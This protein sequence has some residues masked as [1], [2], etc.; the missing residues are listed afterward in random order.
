MKLKPVLLL[1][2]AFLAGVNVF[3]QRAASFDIHLPSVVLQPDKNLKNDALAAIEKAT[4]RV[5]GRGMVILQFENTLSPSDR[6]LMESQGWR[7]EAFLDSHSFLGSYQGALDAKKLKA[8]GVRAVVEAKPSYK[9]SKELTD[10]LGAARGTDPSVEV[11]AGIIKSWDPVAVR[12]QLGDRGFVITNAEL[13]RYRVLELRCTKSQLMSLAALPFIEFVQV[14]PPADQPLNNKSIANSR[15]N[16]LRSTL[17]GQRALS[18]KN[19]VVG[20]GDD[21]SPAFHIDLANTI[22]RAGSTGATHGL[23][24]MT[25]LAGTGTRA[26]LFTGYAPASQLVAQIFSNILRYTDTYIQDHGMVLTNNSYGNIV[27]DCESFGL[28]DLYSSV[29]DQQHIV[30]PS[31]LHVFAAGNSGSYTCGAFPAGYHTVLG[32]YQSSKNAIMVAATDEFGVIAGYSS[33]GPVNDGRLKPDIAAQGTRVFSGIMN[34]NYG[35]SSGTSMAAPAVTG[36]LALLYERYRQLNGGADPDNYL[37]KALLLNGATDIDRPGPDYRSG[38]GWMN[39]LRSV[40][41]LE[42]N[43]FVKGVVAEGNT[44][45]HTFTIPSSVDYSVLKVMLCWND[46]QAAP[47]ASATLVNDLDLVVIGPDGQ[48]LQP[49]ILNSAA[50]SVESDAVAGVDRI[51]NTEQVTL[52][53][54]APGTYQIRI[55]GFRLSGSNQQEYAVVFDTIRQ[56]LELTFP[57][58]GEHLRTTDSTYITWDNNGLTGPSILEYSLD[59]GGSWNTMSN[60]IVAESKQFKWFWAAGTAAGRARVRI[61][62]AASGAV[63][64]SEPFSVLDVPFVSLTG[65][66]CPGYISISWT[67]VTGAD[68]YEV[69]IWSSG[70]MRSLGFVTGTSYT[71]AGLSRDSLYL[72][73]VRAIK[74]GVPGRRPTAVMR[75]P[76]SGNCASAVNDNDL[77]MD[78]LLSP[79]SGRAATTSALSSTTTVRVRIQNLDNVTR[80]GAL[81]FGYQIDQQTPVL[82]AVATSS[83]PALGTFSY[84]F[85]TPA[86]MSALK[87]YVVKTWVK[88]PADG[89]ASNDTLTTVVRH[90]PNEPIDL[91]IPWKNDF[92]ST[93]AFEWSGGGKIGLPELDRYDFSSSNRLGRIRSFVSTGLAPAGQKALTM[94]VLRYVTPGVADSLTATFNLSAYQAGDADIRLDFKFRHHGA[95]PHPAN[96]VW[97]R[98]SDTDS[99]K[100]VADL[101]PYQ[102]DP[103]NVWKSVSLE[104]SDAVLV[105]GKDFT[106]SFQIRWGQFGEHITADTSSAAG[107]SIDDIRLY[108]VINDV[109]MISIDTPVLA[110]CGLDANTPLRVTVR[111]SANSALTSIPVSYRVDNQ[112][113]VTE[114]IPVIAGNTAVQYEFTQAADLSTLGNH[115]LRTWVSLGSD[116]FR[117]NDTASVLIRNLPVVSSFPYLE[118]FE[119]DAGGWFGAGKKSSWEWGTPQSPK[120]HRAASGTRA[121]KTT[122]SGNYNDGELSYLYSPCFDLS[123]LASPM[124]SFSV[125]LDIEDCGASSQCDAAWM[126]YSTDGRTW[127]RLGSYGTGVNGYNRNY[128]DG[129]VWS[130]QNYTHWHVSSFTLPT[131]AENLRLRFVM[132]GD[133]YV[134]REGV[135][136]D[137]IHIFDRVAGVFNDPVAVSNT[138]TQPVNSAEWVPFMDAGKL[139]G[140]VQSGGQN[141]GNT[142]ATVYLHDGAVRDTNN[143]Y[144]LN[145]SMVMQHSDERLPD[146]ASIRFYFTDLEAEELIASEDC[147]TCAPV[148]SAYELG[149]SQ[150]S[151]LPAGADNGT[152]ADNEGTRWWWHP[153]SRVRIVPYDIGYYA[154]FKVGRLSEFWL[155]PSPLN[156][157]GPSAAQLQQF[158]A[159]LLDDADVRLNWTMGQEFNMDYYQVELARGND[160]YTQNDFETIAEL[161]SEGNTSTGN[162]Y[163][164]MDVEPGKQG[165]RYYRIRM[166]ALDGTVS[167]SPVRSVF[168]SDE[169]EWKLYPN[170]ST[171]ATFMVYQLR[172]GE[173]WTA[174]I[175]DMQG[176]RVSQRSFTGTGFVQKEEWDL[177]SLAPGL[178]LVEISSPRQKKTVKLLRQ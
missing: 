174:S 86:N 3:A 116:S 41:M 28:Y 2:L 62:H 19:V 74:D 128:P 57:S 42:G 177:R 21:S 25:T 82:E 18:G 127:Q 60:S 115:Q 101:R 173:K 30:H 96:K 172:D 67:A 64:M 144:Y 157:V 24:V 136:V 131:G 175:Y 149:V 165:V 71:A 151:S 65:I 83:I 47:L 93:P 50:A 33:K 148:E 51:N 6:K 27:D 133:P 10:L 139:L 155:S 36:G 54:P 110:S 48:S 76:A 112:T 40:R 55:N 13:A 178:Y 153:S 167:Y 35:V 68:S 119:T 1:A 23:H 11:W 164:V 94:D 161:N 176:K 163:Q 102:T 156:E 43:G 146:S 160:A 89:N 63:Q 80:T 125:A 129:P 75:T 123:G 114:I 99:W 159:V 88:N 31:L 137:D 138:I 140:A 98:A 97:V 152:L 7:L 77:L 78:A 150:Y 38:Y 92:E 66:Q 105:D 135:A 58:G 70:E 29:V 61:T 14:K 171:G 85:S 95:I 46:P 56:Q 111:N 79:G 169:M 147:S 15:G 122:L 166:V 72:M 118:D 113:V 108:T 100:E 132:Q 34:S 87:D 143:T 90:L 162:N 121:W 141:F 117:D 103:G 158:T 120:I 4:Q 22:D 20:V 59:N 69:L 26:E 9:F 44:K 17:P 170:P 145:R 39:L 126:E 124:L 81:S 32:G 134:S 107:L 45:T 142:S 73:T 168:I 5:S 8:F 130:I 49:L 12:E 154:E 53:N 16:I 106:S 91:T 109:Q 37:M 84:S 104:L 52:L